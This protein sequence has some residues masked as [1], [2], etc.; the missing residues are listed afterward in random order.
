MIT[1]S[2]P[3]TEA[4]R[5]YPASRQH[6]DCR[7]MVDGEKS[8]LPVLSTGMAARS[9]GVVFLTASGHGEPVQ[10]RPEFTFNTGAEHVE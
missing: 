8:V 4:R 1:N 6:P 2:A 7:R 5:D 9:E 10:F 3:R